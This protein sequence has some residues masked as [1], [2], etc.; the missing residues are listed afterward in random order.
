VK[1]AKK[2]LRK[3]VREAARALAGST[4]AEGCRQKADGVVAAITAIES[5]PQ[6]KTA[7]TIALYHAL[8]EEPPTDEML[9]RWQGQKRLALPVINRAGK[10]TFHEYTGPQSLTPG[11][12]G[13]PAPRS[14]PEIPPGEI[15]LAIVPG[16]AFDPAGRRLGRGGGFYD[17]YLAQPQAAHI[18][19]VGLCPSP[20]LV[21]KV[22]AEPH[23]VTMDKIV[24][25]QP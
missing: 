1:E 9:Y 11:P 3:T 22:P 14:T 21:P 12:Y 24:T 16:V 20:A 23:D 18:Y 7:R 13:I 8:P 17:R 4:A 15:D 6:F 10:M 2:S 5:L 25:A 19:K